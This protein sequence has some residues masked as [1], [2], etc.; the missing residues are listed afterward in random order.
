M[1]RGLVLLF[2]FLLLPLCAQIVFAAA[3]YDRNLGWHRLQQIMSNESLETYKSLDENLNSIVDR[4]DTVGSLDGDASLGDGS[5]NAVLKIK[6]ATTL[7]S[8]IDFYSG[9]STVIWGIGR[10]QNDNKFYIDRSGVGRA[11]TIDPTSLNV[12]IGTPTPSQKLEVS[13]NVRATQLCIGGDCRGAW[14][15]GTPSGVN[16]R[17]PYGGWDSQG[18]YHLGDW[19]ES[20]GGESAVL[21][22][23]ARFSDSTQGGAQFSDWPDYSDSTYGGGSFSN[24]PDYA[25]SSGHT[26]GGGSFSNWPDYADSAGSVPCSGVSGGIGCISGPTID[27]WEQDRITGLYTI[28]DC[29]WRTYGWHFDAGIYTWRWIYYCC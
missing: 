21:V 23:R 20:W 27:L 17:G 19:S 8:A 14:P 16:W 3:P 15:Q 12:G 6:G 22:S 4:A 26:Y 18:Y 7:W 11:L 13:G 28:C 2:L 5:T 25:D 10:N 29:T 9:S 24:W 1:K